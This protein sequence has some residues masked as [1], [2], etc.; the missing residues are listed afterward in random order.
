MEMFHAWILKNKIMCRDAAL[1][2]ALAAV[3]TWC[4][5]PLVWGEPAASLPDSPP[6][7]HQGQSPELLPILANDRAQWGDKT[8]I[9]PDL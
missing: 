5:D 6:R 8:E 1:L 4:L 3:G 2:Q 9:V 7:S